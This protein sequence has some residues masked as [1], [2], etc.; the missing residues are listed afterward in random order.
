[1]RKNLEQSIGESVKAKSVERNTV[2]IITATNSLNKRPVVPPSVRI[3]IN[4]AIKTT[5]VARTEKR[6]ASGQATTV[7]FGDIPA[8]IRW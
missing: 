5:E 2:P 6:I 7:C 4:T 3:G 1:M 8:S